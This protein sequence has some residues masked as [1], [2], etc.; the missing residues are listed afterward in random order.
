MK[1]TIHGIDCDTIIQ[2][3]KYDKI[4]SLRKVTIL[5]DTII[6]DGMKLEH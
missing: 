1:T 6:A 5:N 4:I 2:H 3:K